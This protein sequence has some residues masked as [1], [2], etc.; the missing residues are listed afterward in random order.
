[1]EL[2]DFIYH[3]NLSTTLTVTDTR[4]LCYVINNKTGK[5]VDKSNSISLQE[6]YEKLGL[7]YNKELNV[8]ILEKS[9]SNRV[10]RLKINGV[11]FKGRDVYTKL[12]LRSCDFEFIQVG[13]NVEINTKGYGHGVGLSQYGALGMARE[14]YNYK[15]ILS[16]Y[17]VGTSLTKLN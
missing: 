6:F 3:F 10:V 9:D 14:G 8:E 12:G 16:Y 13:N 1:M 4:E 17:Y 2:K 11:E 5:E 7:E 15:D